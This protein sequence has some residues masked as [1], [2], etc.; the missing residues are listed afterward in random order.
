MKK[1]I[2]L[3]LAV[4]LLLSVTGCSSKAERATYDTAVALFEEGKYSSALKSFEE[5]SD[6]KDSDKYIK[7]CK[8]YTAMMTVSPDSTAEDGYSGNIS[9][10]ADNASQFA[11]AVTIL[12]ELG[13]YKSSDRIL[14]DAKKALDAYN[15]ETQ[16]E[17]L[18][19]QI[20]DKLLGYVDHREFDAYTFNIHFSEGYAITY[21]VVRRALTEPSVADS[22]ETVR[23]MFAEIVFEYLPDCTVNL[24]DHYGNRLG[25]YL[26][27]RTTEELTILFDVARGD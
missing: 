8:Y 18:I 26:M 4:I 1:W 2:T 23:G 24:Y 22:W 9:L 3:A 17:R 16:N 13:G 19:D 7:T 20:E 12:E 10:T 21:D 15:T 14:K 11:Q 6:Y 27:G 5:I 25:S